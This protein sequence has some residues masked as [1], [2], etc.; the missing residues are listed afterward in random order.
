MA[1]KKYYETKQDHEDYMVDTN[2]TYSLLA[3]YLIDKGVTTTRASD[4]AKAILMCFKAVTPLDNGN[5]KVCSELLPEV[6]TLAKFYNDVYGDGTYPF[7]EHVKD[8]KEV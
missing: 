6:F 7:H 8:V 1:I 3:M 5:L 2:N 4:L